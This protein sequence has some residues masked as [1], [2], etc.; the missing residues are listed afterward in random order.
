MNTR[1]AVLAGLAALVMA[2]CRSE[3]ESRVASSSGTTI[4]TRERS[5]G[6]GELAKSM[7]H[8]WA[9]HV[10]WTRA[11][12][13]AEIGDQPDA[14]AAAGRLMANQD[15]IGNAIAPYYGYE[16]G[17]TLSALLGD[18]IVIAVDVVKAAKAN[19]SAALKDAHRKWHDN[20]FAIADFLSKA[21]PNWPREAMLT[22]LNKH[23]ELTILEATSR[24][25]KDWDQ[26]VRTFD[27]IFA[28]AMKM[29]DELTE[30]IVK[31]FP[32]RFKS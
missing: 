31:Q 11:Y 8:L 7:R 4:D 32:D 25:A 20:A 6:C 21:N 27:L 1:N 30:G 23:L 3:P 15:Q 22:M 16:A 29:A 10:L 2:G 26:D 12:I 17:R 14:A 24:L 9:E 28:Q 13:I 19:D 5:D 18:H